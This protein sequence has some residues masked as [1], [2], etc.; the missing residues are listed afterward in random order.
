MKMTCQQSEF[1]YRC[2]IFLKQLSLNIS[3]THPSIFAWHRKCHD[4]KGCGE[5]S[6]N[7]LLF[8]NFYFLRGRC[9]H[10]CLWFGLSN[11]VEN[12]SFPQQFHRV[13]FRKAY[14]G[15]G[16]DTQVSYVPCF[17]KGEEETKIHRAREGR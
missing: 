14:C 16:A 11:E 10:V 4:R 2:S 15:W 9:R 7:G 12:E 3:R 13:L 17:K 5:L 8:Q 6:N 1:L